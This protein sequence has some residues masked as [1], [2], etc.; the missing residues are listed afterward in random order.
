MPVWLGQ[1]ILQYYWRSLAE[2]RL[3]F[4]DQTFRLPY[5]SLHQWYAT[6][7]TKCWLY[8]G[9]ING[10]GNGNGIETK[11]K[12]K[13]VLG[14]RITGM[15][16]KIVV[17]VG[18]VAWVSVQGVWVRPAVPGL[19]GT[20]LPPVCAGLNHL[21]LPPVHHMSCPHPMLR[22]AKSAVWLFMEKNFFLQ[23]L[24]KI[25]TD[26]TEF[27]HWCVQTFHVHTHLKK[28]KA[29]FKFINLAISCWWL[30]GLVEEGML[31]LPAGSG[32]LL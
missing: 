1:L 5:S 10:N 3:N 2:E 4:K 32:Q 6:E 23:F 11:R 22:S 25:I 21:R 9:T 27:R 12:R 28:F 18:E 20:A 8:A 29:F 26:H 16:N 15:G 31:Q 7:V 17:Q 13:S 19:Q 30:S 14:N 24:H